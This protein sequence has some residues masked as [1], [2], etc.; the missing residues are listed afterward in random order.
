METIDF[1]N[2]V[3]RVLEHTDVKKVIARVLMEE[4]KK[5]TINPT[6]KNVVDGIEIINYTERV[7]I[8]IGD[9]KN[10]KDILKDMGGRYSNSLG[11]D[12][13]VSGW[14]FKK[15]ILNDLK[16]IFDEKKISY[17]IRSES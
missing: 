1:E 10:Y 3:K 16:N 8:V 6:P 12:G 13:G 14:M 15:E 11:I 2:I 5:I 4:L 9:T 7:I 17:K